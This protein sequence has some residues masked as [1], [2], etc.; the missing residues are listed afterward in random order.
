MRLSVICS[1]ISIN[2]LMIVK[3]GLK[4]RT[5]VG[6]YLVLHL[7]ALPFQPFP[8]GT[9]LIERSYAS[10]GPVPSQMSYTPGMRING[11]ASTVINSMVSQ[12]TVTL[13]SRQR[14]KREDCPVILF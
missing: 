3:N 1:M 9:K 11:H 6:F 4:M 13:I 14:R 8:I 10:V 12:R 7:C 2:L 5:I